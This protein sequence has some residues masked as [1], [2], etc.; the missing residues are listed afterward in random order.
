MCGAG[1]EQKR[2]TEIFC[3][4][5][6]RRGL[7]F[8]EFFNMADTVLVPRMI[9]KRDEKP[10][11]VSVDFQEQV[12]NRFQFFAEADFYRV[13]IRGRLNLA[14][15]CHLQKGRRDA[16]DQ[17][18]DELEH[19]QGQPEDHERNAHDRQQTE[20]IADHDGNINQRGAD[21]EKGIQEADKKVGFRVAMN[22]MP[23]FMC[24]E[25]RELRRGELVERE[26]RHG[27]FV[28]A[29]GTGV[30]V[31]HPPDEISV[32]GG[33]IFAAPRRHI[34]DRFFDPLHLLRRRF[35]VSGEKAEDPACRREEIKKEPD[36]GDDRHVNDIVDD[37]RRQERYGDAERRQKFVDI[38]GDPIIGNDTGGEH[39]ERGDD[40]KTRRIR[41]QDGEKIP[42]DIHDV[43][44]FF[45]FQ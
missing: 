14:G 35:P 33:H 32:A 30:D 43:A 8:H 19:V 37:Q 17:T 9:E 39:H 21:I 6:V 12:Q 18:G 16:L 20:D 34:I 23:R 5:L 31:V 22:M 11:R 42:D 15:A 40:D 3:M 28:I 27:D 44:P 41:Q 36:D 45:L 24:E 2:H 7:F 26:R 13:S 10:R 25:A 29:I 38:W 4:A 1:M